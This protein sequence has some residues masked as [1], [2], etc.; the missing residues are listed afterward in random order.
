[1]FL[2]DT[3][4]WLALLLQGHDHHRASRAW[5]DSTPQPAEAVLC[6][7]V[8]IS[9]ARLLTTAAVMSAV[10]REALTNR[11]AWDILDDVIADERVRVDADEPPGIERAWR[12]GSARGTASPKLWR[13]SYLAAWASCAG[14][15]L[16]STDHAFTQFPDVSVVV[17]AR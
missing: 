1:M 3:N 6:R 13:D 5:F 8:L 7:P 17:I 12:R 2:C 11:E 10:S 9:L 14:W 15:T 4:V 16:V